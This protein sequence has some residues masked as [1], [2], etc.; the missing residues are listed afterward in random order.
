MLHQ[1]EG[2]STWQANFCPQ[3]WRSLSHITRALLWPRCRTSS[4]ETREGSPPRVIEG[5]VLPRPPGMRGHWGA[6]QEPSPQPWT[7]PEHPL[8]LPPDSAASPLPREEGFLQSLPPKYSVSRTEGPQGV[9]EQP[10]SHAHL[11]TS[12]KA[13]FLVFA[14]Q[15]RDS[16]R[17]AGRWSWSPGGAGFR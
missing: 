14:T 4:P 5:S 3:T 7:S 16:R 9:V 6:S 10:C 1:P 2:L 13:V 17:K 8:P 11:L 15:R 12:W